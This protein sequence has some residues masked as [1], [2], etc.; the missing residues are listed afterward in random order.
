L[1][2]R[3]FD[4]AADRNTVGESHESVREI[5]RSVHFGSLTKQGATPGVREVAAAFERASG[6]KVTV[7]QEE[8]YPINCR[9]AKK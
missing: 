3:T 1:G 2:S 9:K 8:V 7:I 4:P 5:R 6:H